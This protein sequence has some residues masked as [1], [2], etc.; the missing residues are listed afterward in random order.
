[1]EQQVL[2]V[3]MEAWRGAARACIPI[4]MH[5]CHR[6][7]LPSPSSCLLLSK[8]LSPV[9]M[10]QGPQQSNGF[11]LC[12]HSQGVHYQLGYQILTLSTISVLYLLFFLHPF[13]PTHTNHDG[14]GKR[15]FRNH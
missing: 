1:M 7:C 9:P 3:S 11:L 2:E 6:V 15:Y 14:G 8:F 13:S 12:G 4:T 5:A 10:A